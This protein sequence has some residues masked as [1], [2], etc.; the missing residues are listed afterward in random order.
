ML[1]LNPPESSLLMSTLRPESIELEYKL[2]MTRAL[3]DDEIRARFHEN[4]VDRYLAMEKKKQK[5]K[6][7]HHSLARSSAI[8]S[9]AKSSSSSRPMST[10]RSQLNS[11]LSTYRPQSSY[12]RVVNHVN[13]T[14]RLPTNR[15]KS[16]LGGY[17]GEDV[18]GDCLKSLDYH[19]H[20]RI[21]FVH[22]APVANRVKI[23]I[24]LEIKIIDY[25]MIFSLKR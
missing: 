16:H 25:L 3:A 18:D 13:S 20:N 11:S 24:R 12:N 14:P 21:K 7:S 1:L 10:L 9:A 6:D 22:S 15:S 19:P 5:L 8:S 2:R 23:H 4:L 17:V